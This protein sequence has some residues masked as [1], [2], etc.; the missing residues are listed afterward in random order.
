[1]FYRAFHGCV[2]VFFFFCLPCVTSY[3]MKQCD[4]GMCWFSN[5][6]DAFLYFARMLPYPHIY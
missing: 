1:M 2:N 6:V 3:E 5:F 4:G